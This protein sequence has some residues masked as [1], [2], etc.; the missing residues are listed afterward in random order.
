MSKTTT[1]TKNITRYSSR[2]LYDTDESR[3]VLLEELADWIREGQEIQVVDKRSGADVTAQTLTQIILEEGRNGKPLP[4][5]LLHDLV[6]RGEHV[7]HS[8]VEQVQAGVDRLV[9]ASFD[10]VAPV[11]RAREE[12]QEL[13]QRLSEL[14]DSIQSLTKPVT[15]KRTSRKAT[16][17]EAADAKS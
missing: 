3:Y 11:R 14:E 8:G 6:R 15:K 16:L 1:T 2:K 4:S 13:R 17:G 10:K 12:M 5:S 7:L 9:N